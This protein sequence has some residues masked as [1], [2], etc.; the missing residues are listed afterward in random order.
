[1]FNNSSPYAHFQDLQSFP[2]RYILGS[3]KFKHQEGWVSG[4]T[5]HPNSLSFFTTHDRTRILQTSIQTGEAIDDIVEI[6]WWIEHLSI[7]PTGEYWFLVGMMGEAALYHQPSR[8]LTLIRGRAKGSSHQHQYC[9]FSPDGSYVVAIS[10]EGPAFLFDVSKMTAQNL[11]AEMSAPFTFSSK[12]PLFAC[13]CNPPSGIKIFSTK[14]WQCIGEAK[15]IADRNSVLCFSPDGEQLFAANKESLFFFDKLGGAATRMI[16]GAPKKGSVFKK[17]L[18]PLGDPGCIGFSLDERWLYFASRYG[19]LIAVSLKDNVCERLGGVWL[20]SQATSVNII[21]PDGKWALGRR[22]QA[23]HLFDLEAKKLAELHEGHADQIRAVAASPDGERAAL[24][25]ND[26]LI[27]IWNT[28]TGECDWILEQALTENQSR[29][30]LLDLDYHPGGHEIYSITNW[31]VIKRWE[32]SSGLENALNPSYYEVITPNKSYPTTF[33]LQSFTLG[34]DGDKALISGPASSADYSSENATYRVLLYSLS[35]SK[36]L[37][38]HTDNISRFSE[39]S[40]SPDGKFVLQVIVAKEVRR[41][42]INLLEKSTSQDYAGQGRIFSVEDGKIVNTFRGPRSQP[43]RSARMLSRGRIIAALNDSRITGFIPGG[44]PK[45]PSS[46][47]ALWGLSAPEDAFISYFNAPHGAS[48][49]L[50]ISQDETLLAATD[51]KGGVGIWDITTGKLLERIALET[52]K[53]SATCMA[54]CPKNHRLIVGTAR[55]V[56]LIFSRPPGDK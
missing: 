28:S 45:S 10:S 11:P 18:L 27:R 4:F 29:E 52:T 25:D 21:S 48:R 16:S 54:F 38:V 37:W 36:V 50:T 35:E 23:F 42:A 8:K 2:L 1:M 17:N 22:G 9:A 19:A 26:G 34:P 14:T 47:L 32:L 55:G 7:S 53:D 39:Y 44:P 40:F 6:S 15:V 56:G 3:H 41:G 13:V 5:W 12:E 33:A 43:L 31:N 20:D 30:P 24:A 49:P 51:E 46:G